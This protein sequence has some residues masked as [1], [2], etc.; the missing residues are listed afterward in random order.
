MS[1][2][3][4]LFVMGTLVPVGAGGVAHAGSCR[5][6]LRME[7]PGM[8][9]MGGP[10]EAETLSS[11]EAMSLISQGGTLTFQRV[12]D[13]FWRIK[14]ARSV[15]PF[16]L[17][18]RYW[19]AGGSD[20][21]G[22]AVSRDEDTQRFPVRLIASAPRVLCEDSRYRIIS[23]GFTAQGRA[24]GIGLAGFYDVDIDVDVSER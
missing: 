11:R 14:V 13:D 8:I 7:R 9:D 23:G 1:A 22:F 19:V 16:D 20:R 5:D 17:E 12:V 15:G 21:A 24:S 6:D 2:R 10:A 3:A 4:V 18:V